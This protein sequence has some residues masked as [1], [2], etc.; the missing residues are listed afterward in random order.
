MYRMKPHYSG[1]TVDVQ[2]NVTIWINDLLLHSQW[3]H[4]E[5][6]VQYP[7]YP[8]SQRKIVSLYLK[9]GNFGP[10]KL[11]TLETEIHIVRYKVLY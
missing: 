1:K 8:L 2:S 4:I 7:T 6:S 9:G 5:N 11:Q 3:S 10:I